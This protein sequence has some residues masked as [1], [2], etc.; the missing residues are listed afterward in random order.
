MAP[1]VV[2]SAALLLAL[3]SGSSHATRLIS[4]SSVGSTKKGR[5]TFTA[6]IRPE[7]GRKKAAPVAIVEMGP[8]E[9]HVGFEL[10]AL[11]PGQRADLFP[12]SPRVT[13]LRVSSE[14]DGHSYETTWVV[15]H[16]KRGKHQAHAEHKVDGAVVGTES[17]T[18][19][20]KRVAYAQK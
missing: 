3:V 2:I 7:G 5:P 18:F 1:R 19:G 6:E 4:R 16:R 14:A 12:V 15:K 13:R 8:K 11:A 9:T 10:R 20:R 17:V